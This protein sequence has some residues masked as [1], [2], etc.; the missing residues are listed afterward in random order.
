MTD[1]PHDPERDGMRDTEV[2]D[3]ILA[4]TRRIAVV[5]AS[6]DPSRPSHGVIA[7]L[8]R[9]GYEIVPVT[10]TH[11]R[12]HGIDTVPSLD[13]LDGPVDLVDVFRRAEYT[14]GV[15]REAVAIGAPAL[16]LQ[17]GIRSV[18]ARAVAEEA[19]M[20]YVED[21]CLGVIAATHRHRPGR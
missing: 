17:T 13:R 6:D 12:V 3:R 20:L 15:A 8:L 2:V 14:A 5:G 16:W 19:G 21:A 1:R 10:P 18:E 11:P 9:A 4:A 7:A